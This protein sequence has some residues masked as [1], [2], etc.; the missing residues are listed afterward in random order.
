MAANETG[1]VAVANKVAYSGA[2]VAAGSGAY[3][4][5]GDNHYLVASC[6]VLV[7]IL[8]AVYGAYLQTQKNTREKRE[9]EARMR[10]LL[11]D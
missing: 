6:G 10:K 9:H 5:L 1:V 7:G 8:V 2:G 4:W 11:D 3:G